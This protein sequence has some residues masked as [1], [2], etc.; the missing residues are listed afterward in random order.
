MFSKNL[1]AVF[2]LVGS[3]FAVCPDAL[4]FG[5]LAIS[6][7]PIVLGQPV[8]FTANNTCA[9]ELGY[10]PVYS[11]YTLVVPAANNSGYQPPIYFARRDG[12]FNNID[13]FSITFDPTY[14]GFTI[15]PDSQY[16]VVWTTTHVGNNDS[17]GTTLTTGSITYAVSIA[18]ASD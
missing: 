12:P 9:I 6:P 5:S 8:T 14:Y 4:R 11:D 1:L 13:T 16:E 15:Y 17:Y 18:Q 2:A 7:E 10:T 3:A